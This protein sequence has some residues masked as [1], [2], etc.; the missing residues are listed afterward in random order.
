MLWGKSSTDAETA[1]RLYLQ[2]QGVE[3]TFSPSPPARKGIHMRDEIGTILLIVLAC[4][5]VF[6]IVDPLT[7]ACQPACQPCTS[8][9][10]CCTGTAY[11]PRQSAAYSPAPQEPVILGPAP[12]E[13]YE[14]VEPLSPA[15]PRNGGD[16]E[17]IG[18]PI[19]ADSRGRQ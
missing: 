17:L 18:P 6:I 15:E 1:Y 13:Q 8:P 11:V 12:V 16:D 2:R 10:P 3:W 5:V 4:F 19:Y 14:P 7:P 9:P